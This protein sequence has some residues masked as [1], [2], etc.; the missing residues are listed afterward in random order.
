MSSNSVTPAQPQRECVL[1][2]ELLPLRAH[3]LLN[4]LDA[5]RLRAHVA[6]CPRCQAELAAYA[7]LDAALRRSMLSMPSMPDLVE[8][9]M[10]SIQ[11]PVP[12][13]RTTSPLPPRERAHPAGVRRVASV[14]GALAA[15]M[16][17]VL[18]ALALFAGHSQ[19]PPA[20]R[21]IGL[22]NPTA[23]IVYSPKQFYSGG[24]AG[25]ASFST[26]PSS[27]QDPREVFAHHA[28]I[29]MCS[30]PPVDPVEVTWIATSPV[31]G[32]AL[33]EANCGHGTHQV[34]LVELST[35]VNGVACHTWQGIENLIARPPVGTQTTEPPP[36]QT[37]G[38]PL[39]LPILPRQGYI[40]Q[41]MVGGPSVIDWLYADRTYVAGR[42]VGQAYE[43]QS[44]T[45]LT[46]MGH[47]AWISM[48]GAYTTITVPLPNN[49]TFFFSGTASSQ[50]I[51]QLAEAAL[52]HIDELLPIGT[53]TTPGLS[54]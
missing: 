2:R 34:A 33:V 18:V 42:Y 13:I 23:T 8:E 45:P 35:T 11:D 52:T 25:Q 54:C 46:V 6:L 27:E 38:I 20:S 48:E 9:I 12:A 17:V 39:W 22:P 28:T 1:M 7:Q 15:V 47:A 3:S 51:L 24:A 29:N 44:A 16:V 41:S 26:A 31:F 49:Q 14:L 40:S 19:S 10:D 37:G 53:T 5:E 43:P 30:N 21:R 50:S 4:P 36:G 32:L